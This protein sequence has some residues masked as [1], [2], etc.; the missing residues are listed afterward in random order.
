MAT[1]T[2]LRG[3]PKL[4]SP[5]PRLRE[6]L[7]HGTAQCPG[8]GRRTAA[9]R[10]ED[11]LRVCTG[12]GFH[13]RVPARARTVQLADPG[14]C[15]P[16]A[17]DPGMRDPLGFDDGVPYRRRLAEAREATGLPDVFAL[18]RCEI[19]GAPAI[20]AAMD[21]AFLGG[22]LGSA[23]G[24]A[25]LRACDAAV[26]ER[27]SLVAVCVS[28]GA[29]MQEGIV[30]LAQMARCSAGT[31]ALARAGLPYV[32]VLG[33][34]C[35]GGVTASFATQA[36]VI[37]AEPGARIGFAGGRVIQ[38][39]THQQLPDGFQ[40]AEFLASR[41][42]IDRVVHRAELPALIGRLLTAFTSAGPGDG[43]PGR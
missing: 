41:G 20:V 24:S 43:A 15:M 40:T 36:D 5:G 21:F 32:S 33:D 9:A 22:S 23:A 35:F 27:R 13:A 4:P 11:V 17:L 8:C 14:T 37:L 25:F 30:A 7:P 12:C 18:A 2:S 3:S 34:P 42:M 28:G 39:A 31:S 26:D 16:I 19:A 1:A 38:Q 6:V 10:Y 29:R